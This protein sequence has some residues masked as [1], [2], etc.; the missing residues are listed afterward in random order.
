[1]SNNKLLFS[2]GLARKAGALIKGNEIVHEAIRTNKAALV[3]LACD[4]SDGSKKKLYTACSFYKTPIREIPH[5]KS[6]LATALGGSTDCA[7]VAIKK[8]EI[9]KLIENNLE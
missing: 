9:L 5:T 4:T 2:L 1:M 6:S 7:A 8:H 3:L